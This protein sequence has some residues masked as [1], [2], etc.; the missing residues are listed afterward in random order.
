MTIKLLGLKHKY[1]LSSTNLVAFTNIILLTVLIFFI[2]IRFEENDDLIML[3]IASGN[4]LGIPDGHLVFINVLLGYP[5]TLLYQLYNSIEWYTWFFIALHFISLSVITTSIVK[6]QISNLAKWVL[7]AVVYSIEFRIFTALQFTTTASI[8]TLAGLVLLGKTNSKKNIGFSII[9]ITLGSLIRF[10]AAMLVALIS[11]PLFLNF[12]FVNRRIILQNKTI[13]FILVGVFCFS[14]TLVNNL[15]YK[16]QDKWVEYFD[17]NKVRGKI[18]DNSNFWKIDLSTLNLGENDR[19][20]M[21]KFISDPQIFN[22]ETLNKTQAAIKSLP[23][24]ALLVN[25][26]SNLNKYNLWLAVIF[27]LC[28]S[29]I[30][31]TTNEKNRQKQF[32]LIIAFVIALLLISIN[33]TLKERVFISTILP[34][35]VFGFQL[36]TNIKFNY[37]QLVSLPFVVILMALL[38][39]QSFNKIKATKALHSKYI[40]QNELVNLYLKT[41]DKLIVPVSGYRFESTPPFRASTIIPTQTFCL[42]GWLT[43]YPNRSFKSYDDLARQYSLFTDKKDTITVPLIQ[44]SLH[45]NYSVE[46]KIDTIVVSENFTIVKLLETR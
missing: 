32:Y 4:Y 10:E 45:Y 42:S 11:A 40:E 3:L 9:L 5:L 18:N 38:V 20:L 22:F 43:N 24:K 14:L 29:A 34:L 23:P 36:Q 33:G 28:T 15:I 13:V 21:A 6:N 27:I 41:N 2:P 19:E 8:T 16:S 46:S 17:Y 31:F 35:L 25:I 39:N 30:T 44:Q 12:Q 37:R 1:F 7:I 26:P